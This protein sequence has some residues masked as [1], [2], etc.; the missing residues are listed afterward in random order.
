MAVSPHP[1]KAG[2]GSMDGY[3]SLRRRT[4]RA[5]AT[6]PRMR[7]TGE[8]DGW[9]ERTRQTGEPGARMSP[10]S[11]SLTHT[12]KHTH[13]QTH[14]RTNAHTHERAQQARAPTHLELQVVQDPVLHL[15]S[16]PR[17]P[18]PRHRNRL[19][20]SSPPPHLLPATLPTTRTA[21]PASRERIP[22]P[23]SADDA[24]ACLFRC[25]IPAS[26]PACIPP[27]M[28]RPYGCIYILHRPPVSRR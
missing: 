25:I 18:H 26:L 16:G 4:G 23:V 13:T 12:H 6:P 22:S 9:G 20:C 5:P 8:A 3:G 1:G 28:P 10:T 14:K 2:G 24:E 7:L 11:L 17:R 19:G 27:R 21:G 15:P